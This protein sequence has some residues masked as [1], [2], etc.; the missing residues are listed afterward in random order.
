MTCALQLQVGLV[1]AFFNKLL[2]LISNSSIRDL[3]VEH[4]LMKRSSDSTSPKLQIWHNLA[5]YGKSYVG[6]FH[7]GV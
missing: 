2:T 6:P 3:Y 7:T 1:T 4:L 5:A